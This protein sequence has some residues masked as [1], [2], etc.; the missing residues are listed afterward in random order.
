MSEETDRFDRNIKKIESIIK[1]I[2]KEALSEKDAE[3][4]KALEKKMEYFTTY[5]DW[6]VQWRKIIA[7][8]SL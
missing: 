6:F 7:E 3:K 4:F 1:R 8:L 5:R 2:E